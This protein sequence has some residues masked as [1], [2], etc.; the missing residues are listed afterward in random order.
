MVLAT[1]VDFEFIKCFV[2]V[3]A[4]P[5]LFIFNLKLPKPIYT[6]QEKQIMEN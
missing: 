3:F 2:L 6:I 1:N 4:K 5:F